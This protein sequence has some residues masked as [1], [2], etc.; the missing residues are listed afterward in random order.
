MKYR[1]FLPLLLIVFSC[2]GERDGRS[3]A[4]GF[5]GSFSTFDPYMS[6]EYATFSVNSNIFESLVK[7]D[8]DLAIQPALAKSWENVDPRTWVFH[9]R[10]GVCFHN[11]DTLTAE[12]VKFSL[13]R[14]K[15][16]PDSEYKGYL[17]TIE[18][19]ELPDRRTVKLET[20]KPDFPLLSK[21]SGVFI[22]SKE[23]TDQHDEEFLSRNPVG[24][25]PY[26]VYRPGSPLELRA[27]KGYWGKQPDIERVSFFFFGDLEEAIDDLLSG[28]IEILNNFP[29]DYIQRIEESDEVELVYAPGLSVRYLGFNMSSPVYGRKEVRKAIYHAI[30]R[31]ALIDS[32]KKGYAKEATQLLNPRVYG[33]NP[34]IASVP[35]D[36]LEA[37]KLLRETGL[38]GRI[39]LKLVFFEPRAKIGEMIKRDL[40][41]VGISVTLAP[42]PA[43]EL[44][45]AIRTGDFDAYVAAF[46][47]TSG[48]AEQGLLS[49]LHSKDPKRN[50]GLLNYERFRSKE[51]DFLIENLD[52]AVSPRE[53]LA[54]MQ[55][56]MAVVMEEI[57]SIPLFVA[58]DL[59]AKHKTISWNPRPDGIIRIDEISKEGNGE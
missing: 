25:G 26:Q 55:S 37:L 8:E 16:H 2:S 57:P 49:K 50:Y 45:D 18:R 32:V 30:N 4:I 58:E 56:I 6:S 28:K 36:T 1:I 15:E 19:I 47:S 3:I 20:S 35:Y 27:Y 44:L 39:H 11:G 59:Y 31:S 12:D 21:L 7:L 10:E 42:M 14:A 43:E 17:M 24:T 53:R 22:L 5:M 51:I 46:V 34:E 23:Y 40:E 9:L 52:D 38:E 54:M 48:D 13:M 29:C 33:Y 41:K